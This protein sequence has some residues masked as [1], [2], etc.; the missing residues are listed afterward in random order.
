MSWLAIAGGGALGSLLRHLVNLALS[1][2]FDGA[3]P[4][5]TFVVNVAGCL[6]IGALAGGVAGGRLRLSATQRAFAFV[7]VLGV[8]V[9]DFLAPVFRKLWHRDHP[10]GWRGRVS[11]AW[12]G[13][14]AHRG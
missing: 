9:P 11:S 5:A 14:T 1:R 7:G 6:A 10:E 2:R 12:C 13:L 8:W 4:Y 3:T